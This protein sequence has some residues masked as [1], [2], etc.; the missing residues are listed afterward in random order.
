M[1]KDKFM[2]RW[3]HMFPIAKDED[4]RSGYS[5]EEALSL[6]LKDAL[7]VIDGIDSRMDN[8]AVDTSVS[9][10]LFFTLVKRGEKTN[11]Y[12][13]TSLSD[14]GVLGRIRWHAPWRRYAF[15]PPSET[16]FDAACLDQI[17]G[18]INSLIL[19][20]KVMK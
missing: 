11:D 13:V 5:S 17:A 3:S 2:K 15:F 19:D 16:M 7:S 6:M 9:K 12:L 4:L 1:N 10:Y 18:F 14:G 8:P 20:R